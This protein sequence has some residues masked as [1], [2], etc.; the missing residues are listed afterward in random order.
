M[1]KYFSFPFRHYSSHID[2]DKFVKKSENSVKP[3]S[4]KKLLDEKNKTTTPTTNLSAMDW[5]RI[6]N[7][8]NGK[9]V[10]ISKVVNLQKIS[11]VFSD[12]L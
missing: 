2:F 10:E 11:Q 6:N 9:N 5:A 3:T 12:R 4:D 8:K 7:L 1:I